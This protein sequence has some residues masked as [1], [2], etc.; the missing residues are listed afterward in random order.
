MSNLHKFKNNKM[1]YI[2]ISV[3]NTG[4]VFSNFFNLLDSG[5]RIR[6]DPDLDPK[7]WMCLKKST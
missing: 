1:F 2:F 5:S 6:A 7:H 4:I 3:F